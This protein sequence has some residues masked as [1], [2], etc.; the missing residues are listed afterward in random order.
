MSQQ[1][2]KNLPP[3]VRGNTQGNPTHTHNID[4]HT[5]NFFLSGKVWGEVLEEI[6]TK[7]SQPILMCARLQ[8]D[9]TTSFCLSNPTTNNTN[10][11]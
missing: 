8:G 1:L 11:P 10:S 2:H 3:S 5:K 7:P 4:I 6:T 9:C